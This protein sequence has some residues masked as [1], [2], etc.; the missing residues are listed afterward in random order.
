MHMQ[1]T[2]RTWIEE[3]FLL[4]EKIPVVM[5]IITAA[6]EIERLFSNLQKY[7]TQYSSWHPIEKYKKGVE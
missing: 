2:Y 4:E 6:M 5:F 3:I 7:S 1:D